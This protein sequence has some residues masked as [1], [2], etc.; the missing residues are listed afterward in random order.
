[1]RKT[2]EPAQD[3]AVIE[4]SDYHA[5]FHCAEHFLKLENFNYSQIIENHLIGLD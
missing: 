3:A 2:Q 1:M 5:L 4:L